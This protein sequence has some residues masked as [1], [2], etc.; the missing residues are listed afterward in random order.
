LLQ[1][2]P[3]TRTGTRHSPTNMDWNTAKT[4]RF[5]RPRG[6]E[7]QPLPDGYIRLVGACDDPRRHPVPDEKIRSRSD[8]LFANRRATVFGAIAR[9]APRLSKASRPLNPDTFHT[10]VDRKRHRRGTEGS[11]SVAPTA[12]A[13]AI[14]RAV[15]ATSSAVAGGFVMICVPSNRSALPVG[16]I[17]AVGWPPIIATIAQAWR[18][19][20][21]GFADTYRPELHYM[22]GSPSMSAIE[23]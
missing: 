11:Y 13:D 7:N 10:R 1:L 16:S 14:G 23:G 19:L 3:P 21:N 20:R 9:A 8:G 2:I 4:G 15:A 18:E 22:R 6:T 17:N 5:H 12:G